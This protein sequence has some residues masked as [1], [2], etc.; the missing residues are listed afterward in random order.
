[1]GF[2]FSTN[3]LGFKVG[4]SYGNGVLTLAYTRDANGADIQTPWSGTPGYTSAMVENF[5]SAGER[6]FFV[7]TSYDFSKLGLSGLT[8]YAAYV[9]GWGTVSPSTK[10]PGPNQ[11]EIDLDIQYR[12]NLG[13]LKGLWLRF[14]Y[15]HV[16][17]YQDQRSVID[18][19][20]IIINYDFSLL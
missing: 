18:Q 14:R 3:Q 20:R 1:M 6:A 10:E 9:H 5:K 12:P 19:F 8:A 7:K 4:A 2:P 16:V 17:Q 11:N 13:T 15:G